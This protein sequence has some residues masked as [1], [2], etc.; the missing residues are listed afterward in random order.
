MTERNLGELSHA[1]ADS[2]SLASNIA[3]D[4]WQ[5]VQDH[6][7]TTAILSIAAMGAVMIATH[8]EA[9]TVV[10]GA[11]KLEAQLPSTALGFASENG[12]GTVA[13]LLDDAVRSGK[14]TFTDGVMMPVA[15]GAFKPAMELPSTLLKADANPGTVASM[16]DRLVM[17]GDYKVVGDPKSP[18]F[19]LQPVTAP[20][21]AEIRAAEAAF[22]KGK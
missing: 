12:A 14:Y 4:V 8:G 2:P 21:Q 16:L 7:K 9:A 20:N 22:W 11:G 13:G 6:P 18:F 19:I 10:G 5:F 3:A 1:P 15:E 17:T